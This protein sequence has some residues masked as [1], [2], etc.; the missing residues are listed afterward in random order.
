[1]H[2]VRFLLF[3]WNNVGVQV[4]FYF[5]LLVQTW[6]GL[7]WVKFK[8]IGVWSFFKPSISLQIVK[9]FRMTFVIGSCCINFL[10]VYLKSQFFCWHIL[11]TKC[12]IFVNMLILM[13]KG[14][15]FFSQVKTTITNLF[16]LAIFCI[17]IICYH[18]YFLNAKTLVQYNVSCQLYIGKHYTSW[19]YC[20][21]WPTCI[22]NK[23]TFDKKILNIARTHL[24]QL[25]FDAN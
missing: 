5:L 4:K 2:I 23:K 17:T 6:L 24:E 13:W 20:F 21:L 16:Y 3:S 9:F 15:S 10:C 19:Q 7:Q 12:D 22:A 25:P 11:Y 1:M 14:L 18:D 8:R